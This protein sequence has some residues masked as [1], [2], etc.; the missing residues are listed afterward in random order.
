ML[1]RI[2][3]VQYVGQ[4]RQHSAD[5]PKRAVHV[6]ER[7]DKPFSQHRFLSEGQHS[8]ALTSNKPPQIDRMQNSYQPVVAEANKRIKRTGDRSGRRDRSE[9]E[10]PTKGKEREPHAAHSSRP[11][12]SA[13]ASGALLKPVVEILSRRPHTARRTGHRTSFKLNEYAADWNR[14][15][16]SELGDE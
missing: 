9:H 12:S 1:P 15:L 11:S 2:I 8:Y 14:A 4:L 7:S 10:Q 13:T 3:V 16:T 5:L 6:S